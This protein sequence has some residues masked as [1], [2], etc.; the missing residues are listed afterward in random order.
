MVI[1]R[2]I[3]GLPH[4]HIA[5]KM[6]KEPKSARDTDEVIC[7]ELPRNHPTLRAKVLEHMMH[8]HYETRCYKTQRQ[9]DTK[10]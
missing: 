2:L 7:A 6:R 5:V 9:K 1:F 4:A 3:V 8:A 10:R